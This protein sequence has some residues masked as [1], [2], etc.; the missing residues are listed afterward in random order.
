MLHVHTAGTL[1]LLQVQQL[2]LRLKVLHCRL[3]FCVF[4]AVLQLCLNYSCTS[5]LQAANCSSNTTSSALPA[6]LEDPPVFQ[7]HILIDSCLPFQFGPNVEFACFLARRNPEHKSFSACLRHAKMSMQCSED[8]RM[9]LQFLCCKFHCVIWAIGKKMQMEI[10]EV[11]WPFW[12]DL[13]WL[14]GTVDLSESEIFDVGFEAHLCASFACLQVLGFG[15]HSQ[16]QI[17]FFLHERTARSREIHR[18]GLPESHLPGS[19]RGQ[20]GSPS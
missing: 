11:L 9:R 16:L 3:A 15:E 17:N 19:N 1:V 12:H 8:E 14:A 18:L 5:L 6:I 4:W 10:S 7:R 2:R 20:E 13:Q